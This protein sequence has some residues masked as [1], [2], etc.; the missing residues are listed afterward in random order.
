[1]EEKEQKE[2]KK[3]KNPRGNC[4]CMCADMHSHIHMYAPMHN[5]K[6]YKIYIS[7]VRV[8]Y[9]T[10]QDALLP[11]Y[12]FKYR[13]VCMCYW[14]PCKNDNLSAAQAAALLFEV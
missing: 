6:L 5:R 2:K 14:K 13:C 8:Q 1:M 3:K 7:G 9:S 11:T 12:L 4:F 10:V